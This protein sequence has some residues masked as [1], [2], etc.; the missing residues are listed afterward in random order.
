M[1]VTTD[2]PGIRSNIV[3]Y[4]LSA[5]VCSLNPS[6]MVGGTGSIS[7]GTAPMVSPQ[8]HRNRRFVLTDDR[9]GSVGGRISQVTWGKDVTNFTAET[10]LQRLN[11]ESS[12]PPQYGV[13]MAAAMDVVLSKAGMTSTGLPTT[14]TV[15]FP[16]FKGAILDYLKN[17]C[18]VYDY[19]YY[20]DSAAMDVVNFRAIR[21]TTFTGNYSSIEYS[22]NDQTVAQNVEVNQYTYTVPGSPSANI[23]FAPFAVDDPQILTVDAGQTISYDIKCN[24]WLASI[25]QPVAMDLVGPEERTD[26]GAYCVAGSDG[27]PIPASQWEGLGGSISVSLADDPSIIHVVIVAPAASVMK[28]TSGEDTFSPY[29]IAATAVD[30]NAFYNSL[31]ITGKG[32]R[33]VKTTATFPTAATSIVSM[34]EVGTTVDN[35][36]ISSPTQLW[37]AGV[38]A[39]QGYAGA[40]H[41][42]TAAFIPAAGIAYTQVLGGRCQGDGAKFRVTSVSTA[43]EGLTLTGNSDTLFSDFDAVWAGK[44]CGDFDAAK[45]G[46]TFNTFAVTPTNTN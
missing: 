15:T 23:E 1:G 14:G 42:L 9:F 33:Y 22:V 46:Q 20:A 2:I 6:D 44:T 38:S 21:S 7:F 12:I 41:T 5:E 13:T 29:S 10:M 11:I 18:V 26:S 32:V 19:E 45:V 43:A 40:D 39:A 25:N 34:E 36:F 28:N 35:P 17:F 24:G 4:A 3:S 16:G 31:H 8:V 27:L 37:R 30:E